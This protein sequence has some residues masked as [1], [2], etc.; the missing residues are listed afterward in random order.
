MGFSVDLVET[1]SD[2]IQELICA[3][4][5]VGLALSRMF[6]VFMVRSRASVI[7]HQSTA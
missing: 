7:R 5:Q 3:V 6:R 2:L 1:P 4:C